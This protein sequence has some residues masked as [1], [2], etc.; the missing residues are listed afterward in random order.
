[1]ED[2]VS[3]DFWRGKRV[4]VTGHTGFKGAWLC[5]WLTE[6]GADVT[7]YALPPEGEGI[8][9]DCSV[10]ERVRSRIGDLA[11]LEK[12]KRTFAET[13]PEVVFHLAAQSLVRRS[14]REPLTTLSTNVLGTAHVLEAVRSTDTVRSVVVVTTD[15]CYENREWV[16]GYRESDRLGGRDPYSASKAAAEI[17][18]AAYRESFFP[19]DRYD[20]H[21]VAIAT[22]RAGNV[23]GGGD[24]AE[25]RLIPDIMRALAAGR[26]V[27]VRNPTAIRPWQHVLEPL[28]GYLQ[29]ARRLYLDGAPFASAWNFGPS[30]ESARPV[31]W[32]VDYVLAR[33]EGNQGAVSYDGGS[34]HEAHYLKLDSTKAIAE[35]RWHPVLSLEAALDLVIEWH[36]ARRRNQ[37]MHEFTVSQIR[38]YER[39][40]RQGTH[41]ES[42]SGA[43]Q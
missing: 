18:T 39:V 12:L 38:D 9:Q 10:E 26:P 2:L 3:G 1:M 40:V 20:E 37:P 14:Y 7:G 24:W 19:V 16:W 33:W 22:A 28:A 35:L 34:L 31:S 36:Q 8:F 29:L 25:D 5:V 43:P 21:R 41:R 17:V 27:P 23:I 11:D 15:K 4:L 30:M 42:V 13:R 32:I 6:M